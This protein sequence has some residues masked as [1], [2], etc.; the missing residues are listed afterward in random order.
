MAQGQFLGAQSNWKDPMF[1]DSGHVPLGSGIWADVV[2]SVVLSGVLA[3]LGDQL[4]S[5]STWICR[6][7]LS[8]VSILLGDLLS[9]I[10][11]WVRRSVA[12]GLLKVQVETGRILSQA[13]SRFLCPGGSGQVPW[14]RSGGPTCAHRC[15]S[16]PGRPALSW[17]YLGMESCGTGSAPGC[18]WKLQIWSFY[19]PLQNC[20]G[21][22]FVSASV[23]IVSIILFS[24]PSYLYVY[25]CWALKTASLVAIPGLIHQVL[26][27]LGKIF[28]SDLL[29]STSHSRCCL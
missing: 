13:A 18:R 23:N 24:T 14:S 25:W 10:R 3:L 17:C 5:G 19:P 26:H 4:F 9:P 2:V 28:F 7:V 16:T 27:T 21:V 6:T 12:Q 15:V 1:W 11:I 22:A 29:R 8:S 20:L